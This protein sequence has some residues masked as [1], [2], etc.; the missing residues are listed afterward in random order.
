MIQNTHRPTQLATYISEATECKI[1]LPKISDYN[2][3]YLNI[4]W[5]K[6]TIVL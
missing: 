3:P 5:V 2:F 6:L 4:F 1:Q